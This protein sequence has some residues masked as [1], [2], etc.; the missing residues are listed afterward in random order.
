MKLNFSRLTSLWRAELS[1]PKD[2]VR[3]A[4]FIAF[5]FLLAHLAGLRE[6]TSLLNGTPGSVQLGWAWSGILGLTYIFAYLGF[7]L[8]VPIFLLAAG[9]LATWRRFSSRTSS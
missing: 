7:V 6:F 4:C 1:S 9:L 2:F 5:F 3:R 8:L